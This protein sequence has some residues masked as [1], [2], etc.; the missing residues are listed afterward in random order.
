[1]SLLEKLW[2]KNSGWG[3]WVVK[4]SFEIFCSIK[5]VLKKNKEISN[6]KRAGI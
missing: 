2:I 5:L 6:K 3:E 4:G 1:M